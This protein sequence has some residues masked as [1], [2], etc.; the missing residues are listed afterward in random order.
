LKFKNE[1]WKDCFKS[2]ENEKLIDILLNGEEI[3]IETKKDP[4]AVYYAILEKSKFSTENERENKARFFCMQNIFY[5]G[6]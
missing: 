6:F 3:K 5:P 2:I 1:S 4:Y